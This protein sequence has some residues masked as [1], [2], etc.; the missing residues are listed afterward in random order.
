MAPASAWRS[1]IRSDRLRRL[2]IANADVRQRG[3]AIELHPEIDTVLREHKLWVVIAGGLLCC[4]MHAISSEQMACA[5]YI[6]TVRA[7]LCGLAWS[8]AKAQKEEIVEVRNYMTSQKQL[9]TCGPVH[10]HPGAAVPCPFLPANAACSK[11]E[12]HI[13]TF[14]QSPFCR[15]QLQASSCSDNLVKRR[16]DA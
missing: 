5:V 7:G 2:Q 15:W 13:H 16:A 12:Q 14:I 4:F 11:Q 6:K 10:H 1:W 9:D 3:F 8:H